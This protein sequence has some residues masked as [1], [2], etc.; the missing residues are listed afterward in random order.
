[1]KGLLKNN[2]FA[3]RSNAKAFSVF[4]LLLGIFV[5]AVISPSLLMGYALLGMIGFSL[6]AIAGLRK[7]SSTK[8]SKYKLTAPVKRS[9]I[10]KSYF[11]SQIL[12]LIVGIAYAGI[13]VA[14]S[15][16]LHG[17]TLDRNVDIFMLFV[18]GI[19][20]SLSM[21]AIFFPLFYL[22]GEERNE[23]FLIISL[24]CG[25][26]IVM[27]L[28]TLINTLFPKMTAP[29]LICG[30]IAILVHFVFEIPLNDCLIFLVEEL[31]NFPNNDFATGIPFLKPV[32]HSFSIAILGTPTFCI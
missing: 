18:V 12:W 30:G 29:Q 27:G 1:M 22:G 13:G 5:V 23:V 7:E 28:S 3:V 25:I 14:L 24:L 4:M 16:M 2:Y 26:G 17:V 8:W 15:I 20:I 9:D 6:N 10:V 21:G 31:F 11:I 19:G 32:L